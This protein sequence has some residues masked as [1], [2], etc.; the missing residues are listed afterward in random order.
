MQKQQQKKN[1]IKADTRK[2]RKYKYEDEGSESREKMAKMKKK[3][4][5][6]SWEEKDLTQ[7]IK[8]SFTVRF[9]A[10]LNSKVEKREG[11]EMRGVQPLAIGLCS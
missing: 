1:K 11:N 5:E 8:S 2:T 7:Q 6:T 10:N 4:K 3:K 9:F